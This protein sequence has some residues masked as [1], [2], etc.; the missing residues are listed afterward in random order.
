MKTQSELHGDMQRP[1][2]MIARLPV[3]QVTKV[4]DGT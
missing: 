1:S 4:T 3:R 2:E